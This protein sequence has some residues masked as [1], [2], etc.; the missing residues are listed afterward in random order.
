MPILIE[1]V[2]S[3]FWHRL[4]VRREL[5]QNS[6]AESILLIRFDS[7]LRRSYLGIQAK[8]NPRSPMRNHN[9]LKAAIDDDDPN[10]AAMVVRQALGIES[11]GFSY[12]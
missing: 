3:I 12:D 11:D 7:R 8:P 4:K 1:E 5:V 6:N 2:G 9:L 10:H